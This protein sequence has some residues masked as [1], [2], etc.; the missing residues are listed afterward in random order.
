MTF[1]SLI[2]IVAELTAATVMLCLARTGMKDHGTLIQ[3]LSAGN[4]LM[5]LVC[6]AQ[7]CSATLPMDR[8]TLDGVGAAAV[9]VTV[10]R[11]AGLLG[12]NQL[13]KAER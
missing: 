2:P 11:L 10:I 8:V 7:A 5:A 1:D 6:F 3:A 4:L 13:W 12:T 9:A